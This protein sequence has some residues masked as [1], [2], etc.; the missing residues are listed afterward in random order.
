MILPLELP[1]VDLAQERAEKRGTK[2][3]KARIALCEDNMPPLRAW[4]FSF[5]TSAS[6]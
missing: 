4:A 6:I 3:F 5:V 2:R 1:T